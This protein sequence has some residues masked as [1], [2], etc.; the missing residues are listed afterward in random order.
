LAL[1]QFGEHVVFEA[2][3]SI[4]AVE[5]AQGL[6]FPEDDSGFESKALALHL[7]REA[8]VPRTAP[9]VFLDRGA[10]DH[11]A[12]A[13]VGHWSLTASEVAS[14]T[15]TG[16]DLAFLVEPPPDGVSTL[17]RVEAAFCHRLVYAIEEAYR[18]LRI[19]IVRVS[20]ATLDVRVQF[21][22]GTLP[23]AS[24][25]AGHAWEDAANSDLT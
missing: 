12:Y 20:Y 13:Q 11:L 25:D 22:L 9:R 21:I 18:A 14:C 8:Q 19:P 16:Y 4:R 23:I 2:A 3:S 24:I 7:R 10:P 6:T 15:Q 5:R 17:N 1:E